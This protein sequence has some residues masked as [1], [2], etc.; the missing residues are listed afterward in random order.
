MK[1]LHYKW[2]RQMSSFYIYMAGT[3]RAIIKVL[4]NGTPEEQEKIA[5]DIVNTVNNSTA[6]HKLPQAKARGFLAEIS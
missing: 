6:N 3:D 1:K 5:K 4:N 2:M